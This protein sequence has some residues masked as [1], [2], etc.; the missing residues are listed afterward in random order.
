MNWPGKTL[1]SSIGKKSIMALSGAF[2]GL[3]VAVPVLGHATWHA[4]R[5]MRQDPVGDATIEVLDGA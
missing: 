4:Y 3:F 1:S 5:T 2:L